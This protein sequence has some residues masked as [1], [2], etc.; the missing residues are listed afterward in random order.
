MGGVGAALPLHEAARDSAPGSAM[1][2][3]PVAAYE[4]AK[5]QRDQ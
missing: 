5:A 2:R 3:Q 4:H 1:F